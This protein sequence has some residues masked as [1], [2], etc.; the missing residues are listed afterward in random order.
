M[1]A[2]VFRALRW[3]VLLNNNE[4]KFDSLLSSIFIGFSIN[5]ILPARTGDIYRAYFFS[6]KEKLGKTKVFTSVI[7]ERIFDGFTLFIIL[8]TAI[9]LINPGDLFSKIAFSAGAV[10]ISG[11]ILL[12]VLVRIKNTGDKREKIKLLLL[13]LLGFL[14][15]KIKIS[16]EKLINKFFS[17]L[18]SFIE[19]LATLNSWSSLIK[20]CFYSF[21]IWMI[22]GSFVFI[23]IKSF[24]IN[25]SFIGALL[26]LTVTAFCTLIP[27]GPAGIGPYQWGYIIAL[28][29]FGI[30]HELG[31]A[32]SII[33]QLLI[34]IL[35]LS[36]GSF[37]FWREH[38]KF[39]EI[40][41]NLEE[42][43]KL[44]EC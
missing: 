30:Q 39:D 9:Y 40:K 12:L 29:V 18:N 16:S 4:L 15:E 6:K 8:L 35:I 21:L 5:C 1:L 41:Q 26:V 43:Q 24:G 10:F 34:I 20:A 25:V 27:A 28:S 42:K 17:I 32:I 7:L 19:G 3:K 11:F 33:N 36:V 44:T 22:E 38:I 13:K 2:F 23:V 37:F 14:P 31:L